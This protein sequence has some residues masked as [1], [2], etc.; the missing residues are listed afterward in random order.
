M[1]AVYLF[2]GA[3]LQSI[4]TSTGGTLETQ[5]VH[6]YIHNTNAHISNI[7]NLTPIMARTNDR[8]TSCLKRSQHNSLKKII[9]I[10]LV[11]FMSSVNS[12]HLSLPVQIKS[13]WEKNPILRLAPC[14]PSMEILPC[15]LLAKRWIAG[16]P[17]DFVEEKTTRA[18]VDEQKVRNCDGKTPPKTRLFIMYQVI[19]ASFPCFG[20][21]WFMGSWQLRSI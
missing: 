15:P 11:F 9:A 16:F 17:C 13:L 2:F 18:T 19:V 10:Q 1:Y 14:A 12:Y 6:R 3:P 20:C 8:D 7:F 21:V 5:G 4:T